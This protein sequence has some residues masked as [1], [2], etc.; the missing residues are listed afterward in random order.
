MAPRK[1]QPTTQAPKPAPKKRKTK[2]EGTGAQPRMKNGRVKAPN[3]GRPTS[4][5]PE[6]AKLICD[7]LANGE[8]L[9]SIC[10]T[11][12]YPDDCTVRHWALNN[13]HEFYQQYT[14]AKILGYHR[15]AEEIIEFSDETKVDPG[16]VAR[17]RLMVDTR[18]WLL[19]KC[20]PKI[21]GDKLAL[22]DP[23]GSTLKI[24]FVR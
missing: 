9:I 16:S 8:T 13:D 12:G 14:H 11:P 19:S 4:Y 24:E 15:M 3:H 1:K 22:T 7:R 5:T 2:A 17:S 23:D 6:I 18:K 21:Y 20:L 10:K